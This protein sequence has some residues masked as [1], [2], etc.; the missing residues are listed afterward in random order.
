MRMYSFYISCSTSET[1]LSVFISTRNMVISSCHFKMTNGLKMHQKQS[2]RV[3]NSK[4]FWGGEREGD[5]LRIP[6]EGGLLQAVPLYPPPHTPKFSLS[7]I[8]HP[9]VHYSKLNPDYGIHIPPV[10]TRSDSI[11]PT[12][13]STTFHLPLAHEIQHPLMQYLNIYCTLLHAIINSL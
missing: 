11:S 8:M 13:Q 4:N 12:H 1:G 10:S 7:I 9:L 3:Y 5:S 2:Q 6:L